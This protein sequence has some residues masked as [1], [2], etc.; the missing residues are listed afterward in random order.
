MWKVICTCTFNAK[1]C[2]ALGQ[3]RKINI[4]IY[5][6]FSLFGSQIMKDIHSKI[7]N[8]M[9]WV[10]NWAF[11]LFFFPECDINGL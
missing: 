4:Y 9:I 5:S 3:R 10:E 7:R 2:I 11:S 8:E 1:A 6:I